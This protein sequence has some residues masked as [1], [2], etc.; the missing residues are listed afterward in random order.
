MLRRMPDA[1][2]RMP[3]AGCRMP[4]AGCR[5]PDAGCRMPDAT[6]R[7]GYSRVDLA[8]ECA[9]RAEASVISLRAKRTSPR[10]ATFPPGG[11]HE[12][13][14]THHEKWDMHDEKWDMHDEKWDMHGERTLS[15]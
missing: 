1:G 12:K 5:M 15:R 14:D 4:D 11:I 2:C 6:T 8:R 13:R 7:E 3:D 9:L 10:E